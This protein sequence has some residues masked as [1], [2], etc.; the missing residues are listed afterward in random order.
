MAS[1]IFVDT[2]G[3]YALLVLRD[4]KHAMA[5]RLLRKAQREKI[6]FQTTDYVLDETVAL[7]HA[8]RC[9]HLISPLLDSVFASSAC[10]VRW[11]DAN[12]FMQACQFL[13]KHRDHGWS[14]TDCLSFVT[15]KEL[16]LHEAL[17]KDAHFRQAGFSALLIET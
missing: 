1:D 14:L 3:F 16:G 15:M 8:R 6:R 11:T 4:D 10:T 7:L 2:S 13:L 9:S 12:R 5:S 17:T